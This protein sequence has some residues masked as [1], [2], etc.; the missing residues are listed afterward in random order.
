ML[1]LDM[2]VTALREL[3]GN[4][5]ATFTDLV[6]NNVVRGT[7]QADVINTGNGND[8]IYSGGGNDEID[9]GAGND[10][11]DAGTGDDSVRAGAGNDTV[12][13][14]DGNDRLFGDDGS[15]WLYG[16]SGN[17]YLDGGLGNDWIFGGSGADLLLGG[18]GSDQMWGGA[19]DDSLLGEG[20]ND[21]LRGEAG[22]DL[23]DGGVGN[24]WLSGGTGNDYL[25]GGLGADVLRGDE[26]QD[27]L[28]GGDGDVADGA[29][30][31]FEFWFSEARS[32]ASAVNGIGNDI[33]ADFERGRDL[34]DIRTIVARF[35]DQQQ[36]FYDFI[37]RKAG[38]I[39]SAGGISVELQDVVSFGEQSAKMTF[40]TSGGSASVT[41]FGLAVA[42]L[43]S[44]DMLKPSWKLMY[45][46]DSSESSSTPG[47]AY[48]GGSGSGANVQLVVYAGGG[49]DVVNGGNGS[50]RLYGEAGDDTLFGNGGSD[51]LYGG[52]GSDLV[53]GGAGT[54]WLYG[55]AGNDSV[56]G[57][58]GADRLWGESGDD[59]LFGDTEDPSDPAVAGNDDIWGGAGNDIIWG[60]AGNDTLYGESG[61]D[62]IQGGAGTDIIDGGAGDDVLTGGAGQDLFLF[63]GKFFVDWDKGSAWLD[64]GAASGSNNGHDTIADFAK[65][66]DKIRFAI[67]GRPDD[68]TVF[69]KSLW[70][71]WLP[72]APEQDQRIDNGVWQH[73]LKQVDTNGNGFV[74]ALR[75]A[76]PSALGGGAAGFV[77]GDTSWSITVRGV[78]SD[79]AAQEA[80]ALSDVFEVV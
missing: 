61:N 7:D 78:F 37:D 26:G 45:G 53:S 25:I 60:G 75:I 80:F 57:G 39:W 43:G 67:A 64:L 21:A 47:T 72:D 2:K 20:G 65:G 63:R 14:G 56:S 58:E 73:I 13:G 27:I 59:V 8:R 71:T 6:G 51:W 15:D 10:F 30:D 70:H 66:V 18:A 23:L 41:F 12:F 1:K 3:L 5:G 19:G 33:I 54:D 50:D 9:S 62:A 69:T 16:D 11:V 28:Y 34:V 38:G 31:V 48:N 74:D 40:S 46:N 79:S 52:A 42:D 22:D 49:N 29:R 44:A 17:D 24:D 68:K 76:E 35:Y 77:T 4:R 36:D 32:V 55:G